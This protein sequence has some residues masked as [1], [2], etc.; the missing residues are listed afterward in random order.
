MASSTANLQGGR[1]VR[2]PLPD[3]PTVYDQGFMFRVVNALNLL[4]LQLTADA[5]QVAARYISTAP[6]YVDPT[7]A[8][9][10]AVKDTTG[11]PTGLLYLLRNPGVALGSSGDYFYS[12]VKG[13]DK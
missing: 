5:E 11:L 9:T 7:G 4:Q 1:V 10:K 3:P 8:D 12:I 6:V 13:S 2:Q